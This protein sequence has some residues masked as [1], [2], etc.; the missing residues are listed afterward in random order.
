MHLIVSLLKLTNMKDSVK[1][2]TLKGGHYLTVTPDGRKDAHQ[3]AITFN[4]G[5]GDNYQPTDRAQVDIW[6]AGARIF[7]GIFEDLQSKLQYPGAAKYKPGRPVHWSYGKA[8][9]HFIINAAETER[10]YICYT[11]ADR[12]GNISVNVPEGEILP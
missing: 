4:T 6:M 1:H 7:T 2:T 11:V 5:T 3:I 10:G 12:A 9:E 8:K